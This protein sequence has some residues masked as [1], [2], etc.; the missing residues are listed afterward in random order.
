MV[1]APILEVL[2]QVRT[3]RKNDTQIKIE[4]DSNLG[5]DIINSSLVTNKHGVYLGKQLRNVM[6]AMRF[7][8]VYIISV[9]NI[10]ILFLPSTKNVCTCMYI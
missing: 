2:A 6:K 1:E 3:L 10:F 7:S 9:F 5:L 4:L 8:Q